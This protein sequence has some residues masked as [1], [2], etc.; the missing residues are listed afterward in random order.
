VLRVAFERQRYVGYV[1]I[2]SLARYRLLVKIAHITNVPQSVAERGKGNSKTRQAPTDGELL[3]TDFAANPCQHFEM[4]KTEKTSITP[5]RTTVASI[6]KE[7][8]KPRLT[9]S[10][11]NDGKRLAIPVA[12]QPTDRP[13]RARVSDRRPSAP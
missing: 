3:G 11:R 8:Q 4:N 7:M 6:K 1:K 12:K 13:A 5:A 10:V 2:M 9:E